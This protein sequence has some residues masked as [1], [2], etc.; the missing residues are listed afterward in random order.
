MHSND[1]KLK[2]H[3]KY[4]CTTG[5]AYFSISKKA[6]VSALIFDVVVSI[7]FLSLIDTKQT[8]RHLIFPSMSRFALLVAQRKFLSASLFQMPDSGG[9]NIAVARRFMSSEVVNPLRAVPIQRSSR[10]SSFS[11]PSA[12]RSL[13]PC[14]WGLDSQELRAFSSCIF[15]PASK[16][17]HFTQR[18][19]I[20]LLLGKRKTHPKAPRKLY[21]IP[22][23]MRQSRR[24]A[25]RGRRQGVS[26]MMKGQ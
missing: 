22:K 25:A 1:T 20:S 7:F 24:A 9:I 4:T 10:L 2:L 13:I 23:A 21:R 8:K 16:P 18:S 26:R 19:M 11:F 5:N 3:A 14:K 15:S 17:L 12:H 6:I